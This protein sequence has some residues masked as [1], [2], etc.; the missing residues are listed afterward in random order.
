MKKPRANQGQPPTDLQRTG[1]DLW[2]MVTAEYHFDDSGSLIL[3]G[4]A[5]RAADR[6]EQC[7][8]VITRDG[9]LITSTNGT[10]K[11]HPLLKVELMQR[12]FVTRTLIRLGCI[13]PPRNPVGRPV[14]GGIGI[15]AEHRLH[16]NGNDA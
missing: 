1:R 7:A 14:Q 16:H 2:S 3:L 11:D 9:P 8:K 4:E 15:T 12:S 6:A 5:C 10:I 13:D